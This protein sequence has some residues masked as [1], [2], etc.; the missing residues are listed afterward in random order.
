[1]ANILEIEEDEAC[2]MHDGDKV[3]A[4]A[5]GKLTRSRQGAVVNPCE[6]GRELMARA[7]K[8]AVFFSLGSRQMH[9]QKI[10]MEG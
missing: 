3:G 6:S 9:I 5:T 1:V 2:M 4:A 7:H 8:M 10:Q